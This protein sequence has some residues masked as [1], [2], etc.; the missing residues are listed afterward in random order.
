MPKLRED[1]QNFKKKHPAF[2]KSKNFKADVGPQLDKFDKAREE[3]SA[4]REAMKKKGNEVYTIG[5]SVGAALKG[6]EAVVK[7]LA[8]T[9][10]TIGAEFKSHDFDTFVDTFVKQYKS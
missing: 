7:E 4:L 2:E 1:W 3:Y 6:Y 8:A 5:L 10:K 9:D